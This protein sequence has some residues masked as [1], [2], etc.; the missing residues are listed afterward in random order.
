MKRSEL[1]N[2]AAQILA[3]R[4]KRSLAMA[5]LKLETRAAQRTPVKQALNKATKYLK[6]KGV[7]FEK[8]DRGF[9]APGG[10]DKKMRAALDK[11]FT[12]MRM[13]RHKTAQVTYPTVSYSTPGSTIAIFMEW[14]SYGMLNL[15]PG[16]IMGGRASTVKADN[17]KQVADTIAKQMGGYGRLKAM[18]G[19]RDF[20]YDKNPPSFQFKFP[21][22]A[23]GKP[24]FVKIIYDVGQDLYD[25]EFGRI[26][27]TSYK[28]IKTYSSIYA[29]QL[30]KLFEKTTGL[31]LSL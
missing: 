5:T 17:A 15:Q 29:N 10:V 9:R 28:K 30:K 13:E 26:R 14:D 23:K 25:I 12:G 22:K 18:L 16:R 21:N 6:S 19:A 2:K 7:E 27:G 11:L 3:L 24:N 31:Y 4:G 8:H 1:V 20:L